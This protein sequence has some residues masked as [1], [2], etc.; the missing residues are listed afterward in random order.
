MAEV[1]LDCMYETCPIPLLKAHKKLQT[2]KVGDILIMETNHTCSITNVIEWAKKQG[3]DADY[4][5]IR[6]GE[7]EIYIEKVK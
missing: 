6:E 4:I 2:M 3:Y 7:W 1:K 5:E